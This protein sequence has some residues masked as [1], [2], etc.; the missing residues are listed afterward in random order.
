MSH[1]YAN[2][3]ALHRNDA[4]SEPPGDPLAEVFANRQVAREIYDAVMEQ[5][6]A[7]GTDVDVAPKKAYV[8]VR[9]KKQFA[10]FQPA[11]NRLDVGI[12]LVGEA[13]TARLEPSGS[14]N[15][16]LSHRVRVASIVEVDGELEAWL[17][18]AYES[19]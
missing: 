2:Q 5:V 3:I 10:I 13:S 6:R 16:M 4:Q 11:A 15:A 1:G 18:Q 17:R 7:F 8:S 19:A 9:R 12:N 14:F